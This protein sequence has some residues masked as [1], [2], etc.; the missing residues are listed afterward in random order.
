MIRLATSPLGGGF[1]TVESAWLPIPDTQPQG[2]VFDAP[3]PVE[4]RT[5]G[6][7]PPRLRTSEPPAN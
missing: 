1:A 7:P 6:A 3:V 2:P 4:A 5:R